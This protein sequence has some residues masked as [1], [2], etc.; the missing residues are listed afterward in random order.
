MLFETEYPS[1]DGNGILL[2]LSLRHKRY[3]GQQETAPG[4]QNE[5]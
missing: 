5:A 4:N 2:C 3:S 1:P